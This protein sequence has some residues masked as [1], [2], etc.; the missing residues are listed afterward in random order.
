MTIGLAE[1]LEA[2]AGRNKDDGARP[3]SQRTNRQ[4]RDEAEGRRPV[5]MHCRDYLVQRATGEAGAG[6]VAIK[7]RQAERQACP[8]RIGQ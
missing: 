2:A 7:D 8:G 4:R 6:K 5:A 3:R 1:I